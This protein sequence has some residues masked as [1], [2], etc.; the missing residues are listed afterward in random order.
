MSLILSGTDGLSD[1]DGSAATPAI[2]GTDAN[3]GI[4]FPAADTIAFSEGGVESMRINSAGN[5]GI[6]TISPGYR[7]DVRGGNARIAANASGASDGVLY[8]G[9][10]ATNYIFGGDGNNYMTFGVNNTERMRIDSSGNVGIGIAPTSYAGGS[11][12]TLQIYNSASANA[13]L[14]ISNSTTGTGASVGALI[15]QAGNDMY[16]WNASNSFM[17]FGTNATERA[18]IDTSGNL[19]VGTQSALINSARRGISVAAPTGTFVAAIIKNDGGAS[20]QT[21]DVWNAATSGNNIFISFYT[22]GGSGTDRGSLYYDRA[23]NQTKLLATSDQRLK[24][25]IVDA[26]AALPVVSQIKVR[27]YDWKETGSTNIG[28]VAQEL[29]QVVE[30][31]VAV[32]EDNEDGSIK[33][34]WGVDNVTLVPYLVK[35]IQEQQAI[36]TQLQ[37]DVAALQA[38]QGTP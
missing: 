31:A 36:I 26:P 1:V 32:G 29:H 4:F 38:P 11:N 28:F 30:R 10:A 15:Q 12:R 34:P 8:F 35:A 22:E 33:R 3:T 24:E 17:S 27:Q 7:L 9:N 13:E 20:A 21:M 2:R 5:V 18:R 19:L 6:G 23:A 14:R 37:A 16:V 25:N